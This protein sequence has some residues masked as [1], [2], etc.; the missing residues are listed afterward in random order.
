MKK[1]FILIYIFSFQY[2]VQAQTI[3]ICELE[4]I[5]I[6]IKTKSM[7]QVMLLKYPNLETCANSVDTLV[8][9]KDRGFHQ[10]MQ[11]LDYCFAFHKNVILSP[12]MMWLLISQG[13]ATHIHQN[14]D[15]LQEVLGV[16]YEKIELEINQDDFV[17]G[18]DSN[19][20]FLIFDEFYRQMEVH[21]GR[22]FVNKLTP[23][24]ST[25]GKVEKAVYQITVMNAVEDFFEYKMSSRCGIPTVYLEGTTQDWKALKD[26]TN[27]LKGYELDNWIENLIPII[28]EFIKASEGNPKIDFWKSIYKKDSSSGSPNVSGWMTTFF[29]YIIQEE[30][31]IS[32]TTSEVFYT[33]NFTSGLSAAPFTWDYHGKHYYMKCVAG[34]VGMTYSEKIDAFRPRIS[35][36]ILDE[37]K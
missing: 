28:D 30:G 18:D 12:D 13:F 20:W 36:F 34:F 17:K 29:P 11:T 26:R 21:A 3:K 14:P 2:L 32:P 24:F 35:W 4:K 19:N 10:M 8:H 9:L 23:T 27:A 33:S 1:I 5:P 22:D 16:N 31:K 25:T 6:P 7:K 37:T 15:S